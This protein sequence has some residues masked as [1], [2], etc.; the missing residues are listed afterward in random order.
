MQNAAARPVSWKGMAEWF[1]SAP[2]LGDLSG[3]I[4]RSAR[5]RGPDPCTSRGRYDGAL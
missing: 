1:I 4:W 3:Q 5:P 2:C